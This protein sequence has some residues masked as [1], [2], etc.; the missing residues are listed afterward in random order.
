MHAMRVVRTVHAAHAARHALSGRTGLRVMPMRLVRRRSGDPLSAYDSDDWDVEPERDDDE[1]PD[2]EGKYGSQMNP[3]KREELVRRI[4]ALFI[5]RSMV[6]VSDVLDD[7]LIDKWRKRYEFSI[8]VNA[9]RQVY[10]HLTSKVVG[11]PDAKYKERLKKMCAALNEWNA[12]EAF[13][14]TVQKHPAKR[15]PEGGVIIPLPV[16]F[17]GEIPQPQ[18]NATAQ[19]PAPPEQTHE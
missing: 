5:N 10:V 2:K 17:W 19:A 15:M 8:Y 18:T 1:E 9:N 16:F 7:I 3:R 6:L 14:G 12:S 4:N 13:V 11:E